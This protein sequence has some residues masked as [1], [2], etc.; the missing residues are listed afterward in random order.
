MPFKHMTKLE[1]PPCLCPSY[2]KGKVIFS[3]Q[4]DLSQVIHRHLD[5]TKW[6]ACFGSDLW[7]YC[8]HAYF[9]SAIYVIICLFCLCLLNG[10]YIY[11]SLLK[12][13]LF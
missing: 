5:D 7:K 11:F 8:V 6:I 9:P 12:G 2:H 13:S 4:V 1:H 10:R 3:V